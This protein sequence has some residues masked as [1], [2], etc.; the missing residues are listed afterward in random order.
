MVQ[1]EFSVPIWTHLPK[2]RALAPNVLLQ[3]PQYPTVI[4]R[5]HS[6]PG[7]Q[8]LRKDQSFIIKKHCDHGLLDGVAAHSFDRPVTVGSFW[9]PFFAVLFQ[10]HLVNTDPG[11]ISSYDF[12]QKVLIIS[13]TLQI[14]FTQ[15][16][17]EPLLLRGQQAQY[18][19]RCQLGEFYVFLDDIV[20]TCFTHTGCL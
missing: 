20:H 19:F 7:W 18:K 13:Q 10:F 16:H 11:L 1:E 2:G 8:I 9:V 17:P 14:Q 5:I 4:V 12:G 6:F 15:L 3:P